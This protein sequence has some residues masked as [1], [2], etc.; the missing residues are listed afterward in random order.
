MQPGLGFG[1]LR[2]PT[3]RSTL[4]KRAL[5]LISCKN[6]K[7]RVIKGANFEDVKDL[8]SDQCVGGAK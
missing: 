7:R 3:K 1:L 5:R 6:K 4:L 2:Q 8:R